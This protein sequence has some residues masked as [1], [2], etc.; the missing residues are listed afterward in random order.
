M[1]PTTAPPETVDSTAEP[2]TTNPPSQVARWE[3]V[4]LGNVSAYVVVRGGE[5]A[6]VDTGNPGSESAIGA[7]IEALGA[8]WDDVAHV[9][10]THRHPDH[11]GSVDA[12]MALAAGANAYAGADD[13]PSINAPRDVT[14]VGDDDSVA[15]LE[16]IATP[17]HTAG[18]ISVFDRELS[19]LIAGDSMNG[20]SGGVVG[21]NPRF[22]ADMELANASVVKMA[23][24]EF[25]TVVFGHGDPVVG[26]AAEAVRALALE[27]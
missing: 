23:G 16:I 22:T 17:G 25:D 19:L 6:V 1:Q 9:I 24:F 20:S 13:I 14:A 2:S 10:L 7:T 5:A 26:G 8:G 21:P 4:V 15:G 3:R 12:V 27:L 18:H 11:I